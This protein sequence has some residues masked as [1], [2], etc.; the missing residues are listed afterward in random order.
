MNG[1]DKDSLK[2]LPPLLTDEDAERFADQA[3]LSEYDLTGSKPLSSFE[4]EPKKASVHLRLPER[5]LD[6]VKSEA[7]RRGVPYQRLMRE[8]LERGMR[9]LKDAS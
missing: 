2:G 6:E 4:F 8:L 1:S 7:R 5:Q 3:D 9:H